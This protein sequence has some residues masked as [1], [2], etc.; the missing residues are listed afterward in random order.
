[1][2]A[3]KRLSDI[4]SNEDALVQQYVT[5]DSLGTAPTSST[6]GMTGKGIRQHIQ[7]KLYSC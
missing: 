1:M 2:P 5:L 4:F 7:K 3:L 6:H